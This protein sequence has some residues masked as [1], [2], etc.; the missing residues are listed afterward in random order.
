MWQRCMD[1]AELLGGGSDSGRSSFCKCLASSG[2][3]ATS[4]VKTLLCFGSERRSVGKQL[5]LHEGCAHVQDRQAA[6]QPAGARSS[7]T[8]G[9]ATISERFAT[10]EV[11]RAPKRPLQHTDTRSPPAKHQR[12]RAHTSPLRRPC[13]PTTAGPP[14]LPLAPH[15]PKVPAQAPAQASTLL[16]HACH[17]IF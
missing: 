2:F 10:P 3:P 12:P 6:A 9:A 17:A 16:H 14:R 7:R 15:V 13:A 8:G 5:P 1:L 4:D 11:Y